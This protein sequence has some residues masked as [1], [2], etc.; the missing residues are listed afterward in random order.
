MATAL[1]HVGH[2]DRLSL[3]EHLTELRVRIVVSLVAFVAATGLCMWQNHTVLKILN[4]PLDQTVDHRN[5]D[6]LVQSARYDQAVKAYILSQTVLYR[7]LALNQDDPA[8]K[9][10]LNDVAAKGARA[11][12]LAPEVRA[13]RP[14]TLGVGEPFMETLKV[15]AYAGLLL[16]LPLILYQIYAFVLPAFSPRE[17]QIALPAMLGVPFLFIGGVVFGYFMVLP[18]AIRFLQ[19]FN[20]D[21]FDVLIQA[22]PYYKF[23]IMLLAAMG[24]LFQ[25]P[26]GILAL[27]RVGIVTTRQLSKNRRYAVLVIA[28][29]A[30]VL[31]GQ[32]PVTMTLMM[33]PMYVLFE[34][35][36]LISWLMDRRERRRAAAEEESADAGDED[37][38]PREPEYATLDQ[39]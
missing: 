26:V 14:V 17:R 37:Q 33:V 6:P 27:T 4:H 24:L 9:S 38:S 1:R 32:D 11:A 39:D 2:E 19:N 22:Q 16:S 35:S 21:S 36:I 5:Q 34:G 31:P 29:I 20:T 25:I 13:R 7:R 18:P 28:I 23:V 3:V 10:A 12:A 30:M 15:S 8:T